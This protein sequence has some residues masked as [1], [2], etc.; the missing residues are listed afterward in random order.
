MHPSDFQVHD[1]ADFPLVRLMP[2]GLPEGYAVQ[3]EAEME[4]LIGQPDP[5]VMVVA[6]I[7]GEHR[8]AHEDRKRR[9]LWM[10]R[11]RDTLARRCRGMVA[12]EPDTTKRT[13]MRA[14]SA[15]LAGLFKVPLRIV[16]TA[17]EADRLARAFL[18]GADDD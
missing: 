16:A 6:A 4:T 11:N 9:T 2:E 18:D 12:V 14:Q 8:E 7:E 17:E 13:M 5:F 15:A 1:V 3:W 10:K